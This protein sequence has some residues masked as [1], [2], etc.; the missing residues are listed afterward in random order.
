M[1]RHL[2]RGLRALVNRRAVDQ[3]IAAEVA[4]YLEQATAALVKS[5]VSPEEA[6]RVARLSGNETTVREQVRS[7]GWENAVAALF[8]DLRF[9]FRR[10]RGSASFTVVSV[11]TLALGIGA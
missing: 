2:F 11:L 7:Y 6:R 9:A 4:S 5:G 3:D 8:S 1:F 10:L